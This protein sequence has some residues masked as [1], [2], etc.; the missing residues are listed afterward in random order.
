MSYLIQI[1]NGKQLKCTIGTEELDVLAHVATVTGIC[2]DR[3][4]SN[5]KEDFK[6]VKLEK[7]LGFPFLESQ[8]Q[9][10]MQGG[11]RGFA[12]HEACFF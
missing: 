10:I 4:T 2:Q 7:E 11:K 1:A 12:L 8:T 6:T 3:Q 5:G 9:Y